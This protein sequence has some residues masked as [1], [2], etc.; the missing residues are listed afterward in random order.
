MCPWRRL[1]C[2]APA[3]AAAQAA[4]GAEFTARQCAFID[5]V[6]AQYAAQGVDELDADKRSPL[7]KLKYRNAMADAF[8]A[9]GRPDQVRWVFVD[10][11]RHLYSTRP[12][13]P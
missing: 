2:R 1:R 4:A 11:Q 13:P 3:A 12:H 9:L 10:L 7:L 5:F 8:A 6:R